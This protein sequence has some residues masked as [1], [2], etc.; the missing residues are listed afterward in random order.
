M[1]YNF[2]PVHVVADNVEAV[3]FPEI[4]DR[5]IEKRGHVVTFTMS[6]VEENMRQLQKTVKEL[7]AKR[8]LENAKMINIEGFHPFVKDLSDQDLH[9]VSM[10]QQSKTFVK[11]CDEKLKEIKAQIENDAKEVEE[12]KAQIPELD[13]H[14]AV[15][16]ATQ[17][18]NA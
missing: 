3:K 2:Q 13:I 6:Q 1:Q 7:E 12:I 17:I 11:M 8:E 16:E 15:E 10:Y 4:K 14:P 18:I 5:V 9:T